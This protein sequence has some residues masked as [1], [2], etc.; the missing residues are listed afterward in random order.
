MFV[1]DSDVAAADCP[2]WM[3]GH[4]HA[5]NGPI[6]GY[7][8][9]QSFNPCMAFTCCQREVMC[10]VVLCLCLP[11]LLFFPPSLSHGYLA[12]LDC[13]CCLRSFPPALPPNTTRL[14]SP[15]ERCYGRRRSRLRASS[16]TRT[17]TAR[18]LLLN[19]RT[20]GASLPRQKSSNLFTNGTG[21]FFCNGSMGGNIL[22][23]SP[24]RPGI[25]FFALSLTGGL[26]S[27]TSRYV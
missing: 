13:L 16:W 7:P 26:S 18:F 8:G 14:N 6:V 3:D 2:L 15:S 9:V 11:L 24:P 22:F 23:P 21:C 20:G 19:S 25:M 27:A 4:M 10:P 1:R 17:T 12:L 5:S